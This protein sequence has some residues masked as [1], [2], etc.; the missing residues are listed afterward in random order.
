MKK[1]TYTNIYVMIASASH[2]SKKEKCHTDIDEIIRK[3][4]A[5][6]KNNCN[7]CKQ[8]NKAASVDDELFQLFA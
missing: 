6:N 1:G 3:A 4:C 5:G 8:K 2:K 7:N